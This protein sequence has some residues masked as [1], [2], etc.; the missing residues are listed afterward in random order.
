MEMFEGKKGLRIFKREKDAEFV[1]KR[2]NQIGRKG[3]KTQKV[4]ISD[5]ESAQRKGVSI[6][7]DLSIASRLPK[8]GEIGW[9][10]IKDREKIREEYGKALELLGE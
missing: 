5:E 8:D 1:V 6:H 7:P 10:V 3:L 9:I 4:R 2:N